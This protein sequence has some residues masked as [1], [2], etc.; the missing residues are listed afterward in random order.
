MN[1]NRKIVDGH[2]VAKVLLS[3]ELPAIHISLQS[4]RTTYRFRG[5]YDGQRSLSAKALRLMDKDSDDDNA[6]D[7]MGEINEI[8]KI[9]TLD[10]NDKVGDKTD[11][12]KYADT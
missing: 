6:I 4:G 2:Y 9:D 10:E 7:A 8:E 11:D 1:R 5:S 3:Q 12:E